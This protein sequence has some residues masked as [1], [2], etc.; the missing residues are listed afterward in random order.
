MVNS[1]QSSSNDSTST[2]SDNR[3]STITNPN[4]VDNK[5]SVE[6]ASDEKETEEQP[7]KKVKP[8]PAA[9]RLEIH[10]PSLSH[11]KGK[12]NVLTRFQV[13]QSGPALSLFNEFNPL[14][15]FADINS[16]NGCQLVFW[17]AFVFYISLNEVANH[18]HPDEK[19]LKLGRCHHKPFASKNRTHFAQFIFL[20][21]HSNGLSQ[22]KALFGLKLMLEKFLLPFFEHDDDKQE[23]VKLLNGRQGEFIVMAVAATK[24]GAVPQTVNKSIEALISVCLFK[25][26]KNGGGLALWI[27]VEENKTL[28]DFHK[29]QEKTDDKNFHKRGLG[30][31]SLIFIQKLLDLAAYD[32]TIW[33]Q[34]YKGENNG[35]AYFYRRLF[36][37]PCTKFTS[38]PAFVSSNIIIDKT[39]RLEMMH[40][41]I[42]IQECYVF[43]SEDE[44]MQKDIE[45]VTRGSF[46]ILQGRGMPPGGI[47]TRGSA[48][49]PKSYG[50]ISNE[51]YQDVEKILAR[52]TDGVVIE[53]LT[54]DLDPD[55]ILQTGVFFY[56]E[57]IERVWK[58][59][60]SASDGALVDEDPLI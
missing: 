60:I 2:E 18:L 8:N 57:E 17:K 19:L 4:E 22:A 47:N 20:C 46:K 49:D 44:L 5:K 6:Q 3:S 13:K 33:V 53:E 37:T 28:Q 15:H 1:D 56:G 31:V 23:I 12:P 30:V 58:E 16:Y 34:V 48:A 52:K 25:V 9:V 40:T 35:A 32:T 54:K 51:K 29:S 45:W 10:S 50:A 7:R 55:E 42:M 38:I 59:Y 36:F 39:K 41:T 43:E 11:Q 24:P 21:A 14:D 27:A 26:D